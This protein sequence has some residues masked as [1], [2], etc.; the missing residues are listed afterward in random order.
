L[1][2]HSLSGY[3]VLPHTPSEAD[4]LWISQAKDPVR[5]ASRRAMV[6]YIDQR[7][8]IFRRDLALLAK[9][10]MD[11]MRETEEMQI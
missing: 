10:H 5:A 2:N 1:P 8:K 4:L 9:F 3:E 7:N 11:R 6:E